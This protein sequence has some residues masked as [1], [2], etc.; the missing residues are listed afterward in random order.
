VPVDEVVALLAITD[1][2][3][4]AVE[5]VGAIV[6]GAVVVGAIG[7]EAVE[8]GIILAELIDVEAVV[9]GSAESRRRLLVSSRFKVVAS[10]PATAVSVTAAVASCAPPHP[11]FIRESAIEAA[12]KLIRKTELLWRIGYSFS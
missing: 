12:S 8:A 4:G 1:A 10:V 2:V 9:A 11:V 3:L 6:V 5:V 7:A